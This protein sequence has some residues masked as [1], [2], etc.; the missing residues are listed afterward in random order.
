MT[1]VYRNKRVLDKYS[2][3]VS[4]EDLEKEEFNCNIRRYV[5]NSPPAESHDVHAH[6]Y[7]GIPGVRL[8][9]LPITGKTTLEF[10]KSFC[11]CQKSISQFVSAIEIKRASII[12]GCK[13]RT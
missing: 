6:L 7:G 13:R 8:K 12:F 4:V 11:A 1:Y 2:K 10:V 9:L 5:D 3:L